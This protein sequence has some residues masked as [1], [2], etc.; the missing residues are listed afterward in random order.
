MTSSTIKPKNAL[1]WLLCLTLSTIAIAGEASSI[2]EDHLND[3]A[4]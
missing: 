3:D 4:Q 2:I 1:Q